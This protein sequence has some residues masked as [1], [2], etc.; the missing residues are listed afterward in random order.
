[1]WMAGHLVSPLCAYFIS[2]MRGM[3]DN[4]HIA[5]LLKNYFACQVFLEYIPSQI[6]IA[7]S[8]ASDVLQKFL[9]KYFAWYFSRITAESSA[10]Y[11]LATSEALKILVRS[12]L[13]D[14]Q[15]RNL[16]VSGK[17]MQNNEPEE[18]KNRKTGSSWRNDSDT[19]VNIIF[20]ISAIR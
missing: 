15:R 3:H 18:P 10:S 9:E 1:M 13:S 11:D 17:K 12:Y 8:A 4:P 6:G 19:K 16:N 7:G 5:S 20:H 2:F 14:L